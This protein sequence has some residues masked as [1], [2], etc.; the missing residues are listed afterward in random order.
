MTRED[1]RAVLLVMVSEYATSQAW[2]PNEIEKYRNEA[3]AAL[4]NFGVLRAE[5][6]RL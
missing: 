2:H 4:E 3:Y 5:V 6:E 1:A